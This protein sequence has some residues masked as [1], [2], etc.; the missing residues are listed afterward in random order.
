MVQTDARVR[1]AAPVSATAPEAGQPIRDAAAVILVRDGPDGPR[2]LMG[3]RGAAAAFMPDKFVFPG[4]RADP[5]DAGADLD[6]PLNDLCA[7]RLA[8]DAA[9]GLDRALPAA[10][11]RELAEETGLMLARTGRWRQPAPPDWAG[12]AAAGLRPDA[13]PLGFVF[14]AITPPGRGRRFDARFFLAPATAI[15]GDPDDFARASGELSHLHWVPVDRARGLNLP[16]IT[17]IVLAEVGF[18]LRQGGPLPPVPFFD[19]AGPTPRFR[20]IA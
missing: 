18:L 15:L 5:A 17:G 13:G 19:N 10:A 6:A 14:R 1:R 2:V 8:C 16:F 12:F 3:Q 7:R 11:I 9:P 4:G 20:R